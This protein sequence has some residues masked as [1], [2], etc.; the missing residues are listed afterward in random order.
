MQWAEHKKFYI[1]K[2]KYNNIYRYAYIFFTYRRPEQIASASP[3]DVTVRVVLD[4]TI[5]IVILPS[6]TI[7]TI[8]LTLVRAITIDIK[9]QQAPRLGVLIVVRLAAIDELLGVPFGIPFAR[10]RRIEGAIADGPKA[11]GGLGILVGKVVGLVLGLAVEGNPILAGGGEIVLV[12]KS[13][14]GGQTRG[15][16][17]RRRRRGDGGGEDGRGSGGSVQHSILLWS[18]IMQ[19]ES[20]AKG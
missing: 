11:A 7:A 17:S 4:S 8:S 2:P 20:S 10:E 15:R 5:I 3:H 12:E 18:P 13:S 1:S 14:K 6:V 9:A 19:L 16:M